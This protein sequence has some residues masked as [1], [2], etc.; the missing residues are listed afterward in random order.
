M[1]CNYFGSGCP[2]RALEH[3]RLLDKT[4]HSIFVATPYKP[5]HDSHWQ[6]SCSLC[7][8]NTLSQTLRNQLYWIAAV[9]AGPLIVS[10]QFE[11]R[12]ALRQKTDHQLPPD[13]EISPKLSD[14][15]PP[16]R[17]KT[18]A[19]IQRCFNVSSFVRSLCTREDVLSRDG[20]GLICL[21]GRSR[22]LP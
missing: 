1:I 16:A 9:P 4:H 15:I 20:D 10:A 22:R 17:Q 2:S 7:G 18:S 3:R 6:R 11:D 13:D 21:L 14:I 5:F 12:R 19:D 8:L